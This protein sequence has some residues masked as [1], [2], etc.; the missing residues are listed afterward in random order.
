[1][2]PGSA[3]PEAGIH[4]PQQASDKGLHSFVYFFFLINHKS[5]GSTFAKGF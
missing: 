1:M 3:S 5:A 4:V 2:G